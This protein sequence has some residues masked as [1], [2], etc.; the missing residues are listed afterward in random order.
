MAS[1]SKKGEGLYIVRGRPQSATRQTQRTIRGKR[2]A[3]ALASEWAALERQRAKRDAG[4]LSGDDF[5]FGQYAKKILD[6]RTEAGS[7]AIST[8]RAYRSHIETLA[9]VIGDRKLSELSTADMVKVKNHLRDVGGPTG[10]KLTATTINRHIRTVASIMNQAVEDGLVTVNAA[11]QVKGEKQTAKS[12]RYPSI[13]DI[14]KMIRVA[15]ATEDPMIGVFLELA[16]NT[17]AR[18][19]ELAGLEWRHIDLA[20]GEVV[21]EQVVELTGGGGGR[22]GPRRVPTIRHSTKT[23]SGNRIVD[24]DASTVEL[25]KRHRIFVG[26]MKL[27][28]GSANWDR[29]HD[30][31]FP[32]H[33][34][35]V[36]SPDYFSAAARRV[37]DRAGVDR[38]IQPLHGCRHGFASV[39]LAAPDVDLTTVSEMLGH[40][41]P[42]VTLTVYSHSD[43]KRRKRA[44]AAFAARK[45]G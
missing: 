12:I 23:E 3:D 11:K 43:R 14:N 44:A 35:R 20:A 29:S 5:T 15:H 31:V 18:R 8:L 13:Q 41:S 24:I 40:S 25:L 16:W 2:A 26:R 27:K 22:T 45:A 9:P 4:T 17:G 10:R 36:R 37:R 32:D 38:R 6:E 33:F 34:G 42:Q 1:V 7:L 19:G 39:L 28:A 30:L 21:I